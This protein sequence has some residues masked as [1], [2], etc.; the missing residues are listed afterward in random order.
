MSG[1]AGTG[2]SWI[3]KI[4][5]VVQRIR[6]TDYAERRSASIIDLMQNLDGKAVAIIGNSR[7]LAEK[8]FGSEIDGADTI[9]R[10]N[11]APIPSLSSH[12]TRTDWLALATSLPKADL[13]RIQPGRIL[14]MSHKRKRLHRWMVAIDGFYLHPIPQ[15][16]QLS[17]ELSAPPT[18]GLMIIDL[19]AKSNAN[20]VSLFGFDFFKSLSLTG[21]RTA[22][23]VPHDFKAEKLWVERL[24]SSDSRFSQFE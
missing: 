10:M 7:A 8:A 13:A 20:S 18:T 14:W 15:F 4:S 22:G 5:Q 3:R 23:Q 6:I 17:D 16:R 24:L 1:N 19:V 11:R 21:R 12:G 9:I 2:N